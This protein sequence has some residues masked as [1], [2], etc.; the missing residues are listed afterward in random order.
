MNALKSDLYTPFFINISASSGNDVISFHEHEPVYQFLL[1]QSE[2][3]TLWET[4]KNAHLP[5]IKIQLNRL[6]HV[7]FLVF[8]ETDFIYKFLS[9]SIFME[10]ESHFNQSIFNHT[11]FTFRYQNESITLFYNKNDN[12]DSF[13]TPFGE[14]ITKEN[15]TLHPSVSEILFQLYW[16]FY[17]LLK[18][19]FKNKILR[20]Q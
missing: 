12:E 1:Y 7:D 3:D 20:I 8:S 17:S 10:L 9:D 2:I 19:I 6:A 11:S 13:I 15:T 5:F 4:Y 18:E 14:W 16:S